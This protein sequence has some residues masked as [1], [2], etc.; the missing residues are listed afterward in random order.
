MIVNRGCIRCFYIRNIMFNVSK[1]SNFNFLSI[2]ALENLF[3]C[4]KSEI[5]TIIT[6]FS[7]LDL[8]ESK[9]KLKKKKKKN[10]HKHK[11]KSEKKERDE[12]SRHALVSASPYL[13]SAHDYPGPSSVQLS[14]PSSA[15]DDFLDV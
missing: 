10:K 12:S 15:E 2:I 14:D 11:H 9:S 13:A 4:F 7:I 5:S 3:V 6:S 8:G 1:L